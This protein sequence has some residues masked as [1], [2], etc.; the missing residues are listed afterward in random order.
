MLAG[1]SWMAGGKGNWSI[2]LDPHEKKKDPFD[3][4]F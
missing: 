1:S 2:L 4:F 3:I